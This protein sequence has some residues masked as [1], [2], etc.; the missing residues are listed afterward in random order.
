MN[1]RN[2]FQITWENSRGSISL[3]VVLVC[4]A[5]FVA[6][7]G[8]DLVRIVSRNASVSVLGLS[9]VGIVHHLW[10]FQF[11]TAPLMHANLT[12]LLFNMLSLW[13]LG[14]DVE[15]AVGRGRYVAFSVLCAVAS[16][17]GYLLFNWGTSIVVIGYSGVIF[18][19][20]VAQ[21]VLFPDQMM[22]I[23]AFFPI[24]MKYGVILLGAV[25]L[26]LTMSPEKA[27]IANSAH[28]FGGVTGF[29][30]LKAFR[31]ADN[32]KASHPKPRRIP[33]LKQVLRKQRVDIPREL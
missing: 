26:Y 5:M 8:L 7:A 11:I 25:E 29:L 27:G 18:G 20:L 6:V 19:I 2:I 9:Y 4:V 24:K 12:H 1:D 16:M 31:W 22:A 23:F 15:K 30:C 21:A 10:L 17:I 3:T 33:A 13:M 32:V 28:L 14:P